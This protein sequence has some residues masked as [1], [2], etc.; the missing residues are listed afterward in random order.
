MVV[1]F[2]RSNGFPYEGKLPPKA[3]DEVDSDA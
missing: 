3:A 2:L 1:T